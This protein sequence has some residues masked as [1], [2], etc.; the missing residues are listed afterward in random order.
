IL[1]YPFTYNIYLCLCDQSKQKKHIVSII[2]PD[3]NSL[4][5]VRPTSEKNDEVGITKFCPLN[6]L[7]NVQSIYLKDSVFF[8]RIFI[9]FMNTGSNPFESTIDIVNTNG[10]K[11]L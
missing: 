9:D 5:F 7:K 8:I 4:S 6:F 1:L 3:A 2:K 10:A 11:R